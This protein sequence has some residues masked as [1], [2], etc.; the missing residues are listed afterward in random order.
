MPV[1]TKERP[2]KGTLHHHPTAQ[3]RKDVGWFSVSGLN[4]EQIAEYYDISVPTLYKHY[5][6]ELKNTKLLKLRRL[7]R[8]LYIDA[9]KGDHK[10]RDL[11]LAVVGGWVR[12]VA[13]TD[14]KNA[15]ETVLEMLQS[16]KLK[17]VE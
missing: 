7:S 2:Q 12:P 8:N 3:S 15:A 6:I 10:A 9:L 1:K 16:G 5:K 13:K 14:D 4:H 11:W 17:L